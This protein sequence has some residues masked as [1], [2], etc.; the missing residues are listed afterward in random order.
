MNE[1]IWREWSEEEIKLLKTH[2]EVTS[3]Q[4]LQKRFLTSRSKSAIEHKA[5]KLGLKKIIHFHGIRSD[6]WTDEEIETLK[7]FISDIPAKEFQK[8]YMPHRSLGGITSKANDL[9][10]SINVD[11]FWTDDEIETLKEAW[12]EYGAAGIFHNK[13]LLKTIS[14]IEHKATRLGLKRDR[15]KIRVNDCFFGVPNIENCYWAGF[16]AADG[17]IHKGTNILSVT[18]K[19][20]DRCI[21]EAFQKA[22]GAK[23]DFIR[24]IVRPNANIQVRF[25]CSSNQIVDDLKTNFNIVP[26]KTLIL[27]PPNLTNRALIDA[28][29]IG[30]I[31][32]DGHIKTN[33]LWGVCGTNEIC[34]WV[35]QRC[36]EILFQHGLQPAP[37]S[38]RSYNELFENFA[39]IQHG[40]ERGQTILNHL[41]SVPT[42]FRLPRKWDKINKAN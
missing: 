13:I 30:L 37:K 15:R 41:S 36:I 39:R 7:K 24:T 11:M 12:D 5:G 25:D 4:D 17:C 38:L 27:N 34:A 9:G 26:Q 20:T 2:Y 10:I 35:Q 16:L 1:I 40:G 19:G 8:E 32:G 29:I 22:L 31:D 18:L 42:P 33:K 28:F 3:N 21:L 6:V 23:K 14:S